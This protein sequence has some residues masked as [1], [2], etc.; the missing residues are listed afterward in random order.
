MVRNRS[1]LSGLGADSLGGKARGIRP[2]DL[3]DLSGTEQ[4]IAQFLMSQSAEVSLTAVA[5]KVKQDEGD[6]L[7]AL[8]ELSDR[9]YVQEVEVAGEP[10]YKI[11][12]AAKE[13]IQQLSDT[14][15]Q[16]LAPGK[17]LSVITNPSGDYAVI[18]GASFELYVTVSNKGNQSALIDIFID[19]VSPALRQWCTSPSERLALGP[20]SSGEV[21]FQFQV[22]P[23][24]LPSLYN[25]VLV[26]DAP[27]HYPEDT[28]IRYSQRLQVLPPTQEAV[29]V[30]DPTFT[31][32][33]GTSSAAPAI[34]QPGQVLQ[35]SVG[36]YNRSDRVDCFWLSC[37]DLPESWY[38]V[39]YPEGLQLPGLV[40]TTDG[41]DLNPGANGEILLLLN[42]PFNALAGNYFP[43]IRVQAANNPDFVLLDVVY[44]QVLPVYLLTVEIRTLLG[45]VR[46]TAGLFELR[47]NNGGNT[48]R[49]VVLRARSL[50]EEEVCIYTFPESRD[51]TR[52]ISQE[53]ESASATATSFRAGLSQ[54]PLGQNLFSPKQ[55]EQTFNSIN[56][57]VLPGTIVSVPLEVKPNNWWRRPI[58]GGGQL[59]NVG[60]EVADPQELA[61]STDL[62]QGNLVWEPRPWW[63]LLLVI[64][65]GVLTLA[66][67]AFLIWWFFFRPPAPPKILEFNSRDPLYKEVNGDFIQLNWQI[68]NPRQIQTIKITGQ[69]SDGTAS[70]QPLSYDFSRGVPQE[71]KP[72]CLMQ[73]S[74][75][76]KNVRT[77]ARQAGDYTFQLQVFS[78]RAKDVPA[79]TV[80]TNPIKI[81]PIDLPK[82]QEF[83]SAQPVYEAAKKD[84][85]SLNWKITNPEQIKELKLIGRAPDESVNSPSKRF[86]F[87]QGIIRGLKRY[88]E[89]KETLICNRVPT[90]AIQAGDYIFELIVIPRKGQGEP[91]DS[92]KTNP[93]KIKPQ[94]AK[95]L[96]F[97][98]EGREAVL[99][100]YM[101]PFIKGKPSRPL[102]ISWKIEGDKN[103]KVELIPSPGS[104]PL[105]GAIPY[106][107]AQKPG[108]ETITLQV[109]SGDGQ[110]ITRS[111]TLEIVEVPQSPT[112]S[113]TTAPT[114]GRNT[115][116]LPPLSPALLVPPPPR[117]TPS[118]A[119]SPS[120]GEAGSTPSTTSPSPSPSPTGSLSPSDPDSLSP[121][122]LPPRFD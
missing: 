122:E 10:R 42:P 75:I 34:L 49:E 6:V 43:T 35:V 23:Q 92:K 82:I 39:R 25:Y 33:P 83:T 105:Q 111:F 93:I 81:Q 53:E 2:S 20:Q 91:S 66:A 101:V 76:C 94:P 113:P 48:V 120:P 55:P 115:S 116:P 28:P 88:C 118:A 114:P 77:D 99:P 65:T 38:K 12:L 117:L 30:S 3:I 64:L 74:L 57:R 4:K 54:I 72:L 67:I 102:V 71:L 29:Q 73:K 69:S 18:A 11:R 112:T 78:K 47:L 16:A 95:I 51:Q 104:I 36:V 9:G 90:D 108:T 14:I 87:T 21:I 15:Q 19:E 13:G 96:S 26:V 80:K 22:P 8:Y 58:F 119:A 59:I 62:V 98:I 121:S 24:A 45:K 60:V 107:I 84:K 68:L 5:T 40:T 61:L 1:D 106:A 70:V 7:I 100:K 97:Q 31:V 85:I 63:Q 41:L 46:R 17:P 37:P 32:L 56:V 89:M 110:K 52:A 109:T 79:D 86:D 44:L 27:Q 103:T 50:D